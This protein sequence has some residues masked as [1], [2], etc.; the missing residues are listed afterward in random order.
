MEL[1][2]HEKHDGYGEFPL[3]AKGARVSDLVAGTDD[4]FRHWFPCVIEGIM[5]FVPE[6]FVT[7]G[8]LNCDYNPTELV[9]NE[10][11]IVEFL[12]M[13]FEWVLV[14]DGRGNEGWLPASKVVTRR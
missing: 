6:V 5:T 9:V 10:G 3:L 4:E 12:A 14:R 1:L 11:D 13:V 7:D 2:V 8:V